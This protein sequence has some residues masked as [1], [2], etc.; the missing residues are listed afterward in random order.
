MKPLL[1]K[2]PNYLPIV[3]IIL[4]SSVFTGCAEKDPSD[5]RGFVAEIKARPKTQIEPLP[6]IK[7][8]EPFLFK[9]NG[10][11]DPFK[12]NE[13]IDLAETSGAAVGSGVKPDNTR[14][15]EELEAYTLDSLR[16]V[17]TVKKDG[18]WALIKAVDKTVHRVQVG[19]YLGKNHGKIIRIV[20]DKIELMEIVADKPGTWREQ[21]TSLT[22][23]E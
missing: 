20:E 7:L 9:P 12:P 2:N 23:A 14:R 3:L 13:K 1:R 19:N 21:Q 4:V 18:I 8:V 10:L 6:E 15:K 17:G 5:L 11:R 16:M 22:L